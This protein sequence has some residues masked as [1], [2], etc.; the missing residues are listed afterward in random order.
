MDPSSGQSA[1]LMHVNALLGRARDGSGMAVPLADLGALCGSV[2]PT[3]LGL[4]L[5]GLAGGPVHCAP[6]C[7]GF[8]LGQVS[9]RMA[10]VPAAR[11]CE[12]ARLR[13][14]LLLP[15][16]AGRLAT[17]AALGA[18]AGGIGQAM[19][20]NGFGDMLLLVAAAMLAG[21]AAMRLWPD[22]LPAL[23]AAPAA[24]GHAL[25]AMSRRVGPGLP[26]GLLLGLLPCGL[27]YAALTAAAA[28]GEAAQGA[29]GM[30]AFGVGTLPSLIA[31]GL[32]GQV[33][34]RRWRKAI[35]RLAPALLL[36]NAMLLLLL[37]LQRIVTVT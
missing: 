9:D 30:I 14:G 36:A 1:A 19:R 7:G 29:L 12:A 33:T 11:L 3:F 13:H 32:A 31:V 24:W 6:M 34:G 22:L 5:A 23:P 16:H 2:A 4:F 27:L 26:L 37:G 10:Q 28:T 21:Q 18:A 8:V 15:Y 25:A 35:A 17:Y 20:L